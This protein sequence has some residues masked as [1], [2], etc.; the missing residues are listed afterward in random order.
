V[1]GLNPLTIRRT[2]AGIAAVLL[3]LVA[4]VVWTVVIGPVSTDTTPGASPEASVIAFYVHIAAAFGTSFVLVASVT[5]LGQ[6]RWPVF[7]AAVALLL[8]LTCIDAANEFAKR[9]P[10]LEQATRALRLGA[11]AEALAACLAIATAFG[12]LWH[13][14]RQ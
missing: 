12:P 14:T 7:A 1:R 9:G 13:R 6:R 3:L 8:G 2:F 10:D 11:G 4:V 5:L